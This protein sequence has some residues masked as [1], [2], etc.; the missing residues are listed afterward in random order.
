MTDGTTNLILFKV[1]F[2][3]FQ[4]NGSSFNFPAGVLEARV[5]ILAVVNLHSDVLS[6]KLFGNLVGLVLD[7]GLVVILVKNWNNH[8]LGLGNLR[9]QHNSSVVRV[10]HKHSTNCTGGDA[11]G[12]LPDVLFFAFCILIPNLKHLTE[13]LPEHMAGG[14]LD[15]TTGNGN[16]KFHSG[17]VNS[18]G[19]ALIF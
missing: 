8:N 12:C 15:T 10:N 2:A 11:P 14:A 17:C 3:N 6:S 18:S 19:K 5:V 9:R 1:F 16:V 4:T 7:S 13:V